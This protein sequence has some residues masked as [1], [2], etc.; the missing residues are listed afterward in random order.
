MSSPGI[1]AIAAAAGELACSALPAGQA[2]QAG[3]DAARPG[4]PPQLGEVGRLG[5]VPLRRST[6][7]QFGAHFM[8]VVR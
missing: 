1:Q 4:A 8:P 3:G 7:F 2:G 6:R 5:S